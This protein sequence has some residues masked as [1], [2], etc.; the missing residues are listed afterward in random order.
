MKFI[1]LNIFLIRWASWAKICTGQ[2]KNTSCSKAGISV[3]SFTHNKYN[4]S[5]L[6]YIVLILA[7]NPGTWNYYVNLTTIFRTVWTWD[8]IVWMHCQ[9][10]LK[11]Q[12]ICLIQLALFCYWVTS[13]HIWRYSL[14]MNILCYYSTFIFP[15]IP[16]S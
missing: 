15:S 6:I 2:R 14:Q 9:E 5:A 12:H 16:F 10:K 3:L 11:N 13:I 4:F 1:N 7:D 8:N